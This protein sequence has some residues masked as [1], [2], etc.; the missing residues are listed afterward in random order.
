M[1]QE[2]LSEI[3]ITVLTPTF[4]R[5][6][7][8]PRAHRSLE[9]QTFR[10]FEWVIVDD[11]S[12][13]GT[14]EMADEWSAQSSFRIRYLWQE[15]AGK[16]VALNRGI[17][18]ASGVLLV[19][20]DSDDRLAPHALEHIWRSWESIPEGERASFAGV[21]GHYADP[22]GQLVGT[23][24]PKDVLDSDAVE[25]RAKHR[26]RG[27]KLE[28]YRTNVLRRYPF[29]E[30]LGRFVTEGLVWNRIA[31]MY[32]LRFVNE[33]WGEVGYQPDG[34]TAK[35]VVL[36]A[37]APR[38]ARLYYREFTEMNGM[39]IGVVLRARQYANFARFSLHAGVP[40]KQQFREAKSKALWAVALPIG[41]AAFLRDLVHIAYT[42]R[43]ARG[44]NP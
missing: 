35:T 34:L 40:W 18:L 24:F 33:V 25:I 11:G 27:D 26:V 3:A 29:P 5:K 10:R 16:H 32:R 43:P 42:A 7:L 14:G 22:S 38:A 8:L 31:R 28:A 44:R 37:G 39:G 19:I 30:D 1:S 41:V 36:R 21:A 12:T 4:N 9:A 17:G 2:P 15:N 20:L 23:R 13:D 6:G